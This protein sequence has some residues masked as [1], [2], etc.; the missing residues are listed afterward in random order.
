M[1][2]SFVRLMDLSK[3]GASLRAC[4]GQLPQGLMPLDPQALHPVTQQAQLGLLIPK[5]TDQFRQALLALLL[6]VPP[7]QEHMT[8]S[9]ILRSSQKGA[10]PVR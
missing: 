5:T 4:M 2:V 8:N 7:V 10:L 9:K 6:T 3:Q 1:I